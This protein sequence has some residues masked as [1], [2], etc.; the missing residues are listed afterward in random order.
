MR[1]EREGYGH[2]L[3]FGLFRV[4]PLCLGHRYQLGSIGER[5]SERTSI[6]DSN[7]GRD[8]RLTIVCG[9]NLRNAFI[10]VH[11]FNRNIL[12][13][14]STGSDKED[15]RSFRIRRSSVTTTLP[16]TKSASYTHLSLRFY[17]PIVP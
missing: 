6:S 7:L 2:L 17:S 12:T 4:S 11:V 14:R 3:M 9:S 8:N 5:T 16:G 15:K 13:C 1:R 10:I